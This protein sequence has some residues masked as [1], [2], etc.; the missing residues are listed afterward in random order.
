MSRAPRN[1]VAGLLLACFASSLPAQVFAL[2]RRVEAGA[3]RSEPARGLFGFLLRL[4]DFVIKED[5]GSGMDPNGS[6]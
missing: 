5:T 4:F 1:V 3:A 2:G 6:H